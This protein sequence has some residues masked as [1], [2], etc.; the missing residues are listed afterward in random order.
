[1]D[2]DK[3][4]NGATSETTI[5]SGSNSA[6]TSIPSGIQASSDGTRRSSKRQRQARGGGDVD[7]TADA[8]IAGAAAAAAA[9]AQTHSPQAADLPSA[10]E[11][12]EEEAVVSDLAVQ[13]I[14]DRIQEF[15]LESFA[16]GTEGLMLKALDVAAGYQ[17]SKRS[18]SWIKLKRQVLLIEQHF[19][20]LANGL[21]QL[22]L[23]DH[24]HWACSLRTLFNTGCLCVQERCSTKNLVCSQLDI[25]EALSL[26]KQVGTISAIWHR[27]N[28]ASV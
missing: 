13:S 24:E 3:P 22:Q 12:I 21:C 27:D 5:A 11:A 1:M 28:I 26:S 8:A 4:K 7:A 17:P 14:E 23:F 9:A 18:D 15:L 20:L 25:S 6:D 16:G 2:A 10:L 19:P